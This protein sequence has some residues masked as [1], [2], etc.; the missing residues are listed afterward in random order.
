MLLTCIEDLV[1]E[2][3]IYG[4]LW[5]MPFVQISKYIQ[6]HSL[7]YDIIQYNS[8]HSIKL[9]TPHGILSPRRVR[10]AALMTLVFERW[11]DKATLNA[12][13]RV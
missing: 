2:A 12:I 4:L 5:E 11:Q 9:S 7:I 6:S 13:K 3:G 8:L 10:D 1:I